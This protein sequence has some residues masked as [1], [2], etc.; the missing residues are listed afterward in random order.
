M[1]I[2]PAIDIKDGCVVRYVQGVRDK[3]IYSRNPIKTAKHWARQGAEL[4]HVVDLDGAST[5]VP[6]NLNIVKEI[7][8]A[9]DVPIQFGG[10]ARNINLIRSLLNY[11]IYRVVLGTRAIEDRILLKKAFKEFKERIIVSVDTK[12][13][14]VAIKGWQTSRKNINALTFAQQLKEMGFKQI[15]YTNISKD[16]T[17]RGP[18][19]KGIKSLLKETGLKIIASGGVS[20]LEDIGRLTLLEKKG[21]TGVIIGKALALKLA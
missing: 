17:L 15:I 14:Y 16:G 11:G 19:I 2:I 12:D 3:K 13:G 10:G 18:D 7:S 5:G 6:K 9:V 8:Q 4:I 1:L 21:L 20:S